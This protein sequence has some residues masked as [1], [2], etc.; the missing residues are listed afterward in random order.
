M[1][2]KDYGYGAGDLEYATYLV[3]LMFI[4]LLANSSFGM[5]KELL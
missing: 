5:S 4:I 1:S 2:L 3:V